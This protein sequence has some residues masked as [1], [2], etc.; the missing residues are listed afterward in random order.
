MVFWG[1]PQ[2]SKF[3]NSSKNKKMYSNIR[4]KKLIEQQNMVEHTF[5]LCYM[6][7]EAGESYI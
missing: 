3:R 2:G 1:Q 7:V 4:D 6:E 5:N